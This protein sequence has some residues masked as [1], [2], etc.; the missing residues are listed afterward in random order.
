VILNDQWIV[1]LRGEDMKIA[2][3]KIFVAKV[4][5]KELAEEVN[6]F[7][8]SLDYDSI[9]DIKWHDTPDVASVMVV[10]VEDKKEDTTVI[11][12][13]AKFRSELD[14]MVDTQLTGGSDDVVIR[15]YEE[16][17]FHCAEITRK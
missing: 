3:V 11:T 14:K 10:W 4:S 6:K 5:Y 9:C 13:K 1:N 17:G 12:L 8:E 16:N 7:L 15:R 2:K